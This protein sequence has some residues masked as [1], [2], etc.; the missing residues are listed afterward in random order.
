MD[1]QRFKVVYRITYPNGKIY[2]GSDLTDTPT[3][4]GSVNADL[5]RKDFSRDDLRNFTIRK[6]ILWESQDATNPEVLRVE[7][8]FIRKLRSNDPA[9]GY[10]QTHRPRS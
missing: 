3:Y 1:D 10:N 5:I 2:V 4:F 7:G 9:I 6:E 8:E